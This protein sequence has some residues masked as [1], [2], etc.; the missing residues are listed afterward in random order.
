MLCL[1][2]AYSALSNRLCWAPCVCLQLDGQLSKV[3]FDESM[4]TARKSVSKT[5]L[6]KYLKFK[7]ELSGGTSLAAANAAMSAEGS[8][9][10]SAAAAGGSA[11]DDEL[12]D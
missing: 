10:A 2:V 1:N 4:L 9:E 5:E 3:H 8:D 7:K 6:A 11:Q 12:Y